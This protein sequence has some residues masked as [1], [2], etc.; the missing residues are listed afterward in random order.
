MKKPIQPISQVNLLPESLKHV[1][2]GELINGNDVEISKKRNTITIKTQTETD[3]VNVEI[4]HYDDLVEVSKSQSF[5]D[6]K[7]KDKVS[8]IKQMHADGYTQKEIAE[9]LG[10]TQPYVCKLL[11]E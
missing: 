9:R 5:K 3:V 7:I 11:K 2:L 8:T 1:T 6:K 4:R 10:T